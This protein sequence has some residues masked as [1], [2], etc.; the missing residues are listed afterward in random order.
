MTDLNFMFDTKLDLA[1]TL[2]Y[3]AFRTHLVDKISLT[4]LTETE[5]KETFLA[6][7]C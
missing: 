5:T 7:D 4:S 1:I 3:W 6:L 2:L